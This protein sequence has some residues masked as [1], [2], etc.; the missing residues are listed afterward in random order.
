MKLRNHARQAIESLIVQERLL[1]IQLFGCGNGNAG[2]SVD[3][4]P[5]GSGLEEKSIL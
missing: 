2:P 4:L 3:Q 5:T 1:R